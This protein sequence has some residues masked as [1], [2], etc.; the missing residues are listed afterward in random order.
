[1]ARKTRRNAAPA[2][3]R[4]GGR[5]VLYL[6]LGLMLLA[7]AGYAAAYLGASDK[8]PVG[9]TVAGVDVGGHT[10]AGA[11]GVL[12]DGLSDRV[13][14]PFTVRIGDRV[15]QISPRR[16]GLGVDYVA[17]LRQA[18]A[19]ASWHPSRLWDYYTQGDRLDP[20]ITLDQLALTKL[21]KQLNRT[22]ARP[23][24]D[25]SV[26]F[27]RNRFE[28]NQPV[29]GR[30]LDPQVTAQAFWNAYLT[31]DPSVTLTLAPTP[32]DID[33][34]ELHRFVRHFANAAM[35]SPVTLKF[36]R[37]SVRLRPSNYLG[38]L[39]TRRVNDHLEPTADA[40]ALDTVVKV[41]L[42]HVGPTNAPVDAT[43]ALVDGVPEVVRSKPGVTFSAKG[44]ATAL[45]AAIRS[46]RRTARVPAS[47][48]PAT[49]TNADARK[50]QIH[51]QVSSSS[52]HL[53]K[54]GRPFALIA[55]ANKVDGTVLHPGDT[56]SLRHVLG[57]TTLTKKGGAALATA[58]FDGAW[59]GGLEIGS[60]TSLPSYTGQYPVGLDAGLAD[61]QDLTFT[62][63]TSYG[64]LVTVEVGAPTAKHG[65]SLTVTLW[66]KPVWTVASST[67]AESN[68][69]PPG[70]VTRA[71]LHC[72]PSA[73]RNGFDLEVTRTL[74]A[75]DPTATND[76]TS[77]GV[78]YAPIDAIVCQPGI[79]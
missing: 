65:G 53:L 27:L 70:T 9:T 10:P 43:V 39:G 8:I 52:V 73:G 12:R 28:V 1:V 64:V 32:P 11:V 60:H 66:S 48:A 44:V 41:K 26:T 49:F 57:S 38:A 2:P 40:N 47:L 14:A 68:V 33:A 61:G 78:H 5:V 74:T 54:G 24:V 25:G 34:Q 76:Q 7:G 50:L 4:E 37:T 42:G 55:A 77:Y 45:I 13:N 67:S 3:E 58:V 35:A 16:V 19:A 51:E 31:D 18:G 29:P 46:P 30:E 56:F 21:V 71:G 6:T 69:V 62:D 17:T 72:Q 75:V 22:D 36:G 23:A 15:E 59:L 79:R 63:N 20:V